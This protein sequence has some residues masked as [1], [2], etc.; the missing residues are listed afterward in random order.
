MSKKILKK[1]LK[2]S[3]NC[4]TFVNFL[5]INDYFR[6]NQNRFLSSE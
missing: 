4:V 6:K 2:M 3:E 1:S 5:E